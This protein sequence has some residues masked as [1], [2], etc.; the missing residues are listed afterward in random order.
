MSSQPEP[1]PPS[2]MSREA[3]WSEL[4]DDSNGLVPKMNKFWDDRKVQQ[5]EGNYEE[6]NWEEG[7]YLEYHTNHLRALMLFIQMRTFKNNEEDKKKIKDDSTRACYRFLN[8]SQ[9]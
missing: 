5:E 9:K 4:Y 8:V 2:T 3:I 6:A 1:P 7:N